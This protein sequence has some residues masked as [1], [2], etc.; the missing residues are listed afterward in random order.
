MGVGL[1]HV[2]FREPL[3]SASTHERSGLSQGI[4]EFV[5]TFGLLAVI[6][7]C[8]RRRSDA[9]PFAVGAYITAAYWF[10]SS[11]SFANPAVTLARAGEQHVSGAGI[12]LA[13]DAHV[14]SSR[15][16]SAFG[17]GRDGDVFGWLAPPLAPAAARRT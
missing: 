15:K 13:D 1:A 16:V 3:F 14:R 7:G 10:T 17:S 2:M 4:S 12:R 5:A 11:T 6:W 9:V 8:A